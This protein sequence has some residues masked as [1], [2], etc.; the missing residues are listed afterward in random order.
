MKRRNF[1]KISSFA[2]GAWL[3]SD[4]IPLSSDSKD[5]VSVESFMPNPLIRIQ[6]DGQIILYVMKQEMGQQ[7][8]TSLP[9]LIAEELDVDPETVQV[10]TL[11]Y[12]ATIAGRYN[13]YA[14]ASI[15]SSWQSLRKA[16]AAARMM[17][18][19]A[20]AEVW[21]VS[22]E[23]LKAENSKVINLKNG[24]SLPYA[25][26]IEKASRLQVPENPVLKS[27]KDYK[28]IGKKNK[29][30]NIKKILG[31]KQQYGI[32]VRLPGMVYA[33]IVRSPVFYGKPKS[34]DDSALKALGPGIL[35]LVPVSQMGNGV[36]NRNGVAIIATNTWLAFRA[37]Q[38][39]KVEWDL[40]GA[41]PNGSTPALSGA[42]KKAVSTETPVLQFDSKG[43][44]SSFS[45]LNDPKAFSAAYE[46]PYLAHLAME[47]VNCTAWYKDGKYELWGGFQA[48]GAFANNLSKA[49]DPEPSAIFVNLLPMG[50][51]FGRKEKVDNAAEAMQLSKATG[52]PVQVVFSRLDDTRNDFYRPASFH[53]LTAVADKLSVSSWRHEVGIATFPAKNISGAQ[54]IYGGPANDLCYPVSGYQSAFYA[55]ES[56]VPIGSWRS[57]SY[58]HNVFAVESFIDELARHL[59][60]DPVDFRMN[61]FKNGFDDQDE[62]LKHMRRQQ[63]VLQICADAIQWK[64]E[65]L[66]NHFR[67]I[68]C[69]QYTHTDAYVAHALEISVSPEKAIKIHKVICAIDCGLIIDP[70]GFR[71]QVEGSLAWALS[72][73]IKEEITITNGQV[74]QQSFFDHDVMRLR[75]MPPFEIIIV[76]SNENPGGAGEPA[77]PSVA[78]ALCNAIAAATGKRLRKLPLVKEGYTLLT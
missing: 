69:C 15:R 4:L 37:Q 23:E 33:A 3:I 35:Q 21:Q 50:G 61:L 30:T 2:A 43:K 1:L 47:P 68:A 26:L 70:D 27:L 65:P 74:D 40:S 45:K 11:A 75:E 51:A 7:I 54:D 57:I 48:P 17:L 56:P 31:G 14:S 24:A 46:L 55:V 71:A 63:N 5:K 28:L 41:I 36:D 73:A 38:L 34:W 39:L 62:K 49:F 67:G 72:A 20:A 8:D 22:R 16:G 12:D 42:L 29:R 19:D 32:D 25:E 10:E 6:S 13:T 60:I 66:P 76:E 58:N 18:M 44:A 64:Q 77:V 52:K 78:P 9:A 53:Q 59:Q